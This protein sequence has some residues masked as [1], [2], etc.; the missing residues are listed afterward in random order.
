MKETWESIFI[1]LA[2]KFNHSD[3]YI[4]ACLKYAQHLHEQNFPVIFDFQHLALYFDM[5]EVSFQVYVKGAS[6][7]YKNYSI[8]K[9]KGRGSREISSP[10]DK[11]KKMQQWINKNILS[12]DKSI[13]PCCHGFMPKDLLGKRN[14]RT[15]AQP[16]TGCN[17]LLNMDLKDFFPNIGRDQVENYFLG[18]GYAE[19]V[20]GALTQICTK[21][22]CLP[23]GAPS[24]PMLANLVAKQMDIEI[25]SY[26][27]ERK[28]VYTR[29]ADDI[30]ISGKIDVNRQELVRELEGIIFRNGFKVNRKKT[31]FR[32][33]GCRQM[34]TGLSINNG[35]HV[36]KSY[37]KD[38]QKEL[39][40]CLKFGSS[41]HIEYRNEF[42]RKQMIDAGVKEVDIIDLGFYRQWLLG[43]IMYVRSIE[44]ETGNK[45]LTI[46][47]QISWVM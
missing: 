15:N 16:H 17:W 22:Y 20:S 13:S 40:C 36:P 24:S 43:R 28:L 39:H 2:K 6:Q 41:A 32:R 7:M 1:D 4:Q 10:Y 19:D 47:N 23:Q 34:V 42:R 5:D 46:Y 30:T 21:D 31:K 18:I 3:S 9:G 11:L 29:Y 45:F 26:C 8:S 25:Q 35:V 37:R 14:I 33:K 27:D 44:P 12:H 38:I